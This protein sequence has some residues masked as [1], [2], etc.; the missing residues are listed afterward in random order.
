MK[1]TLIRFKNVKST[2]DVAIRLIKNQKLNRGLITSEKQTNGRGTMGKKWVSKKGNL[3][4]SLFFE[5][6]QKKVNFKNY[7]ILNAFIL[8][9]IISKFV[10]EKIK[11]KWPNDLLYKRK[12]ICGILQEVISFQR[13]NFLIIGVGLNTNFAPNNRSFSS[14]SLKDIANKRIDNKKI[15]NDIKKKNKKLLNEITKLSFLKLLKKY[16]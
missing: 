14:T 2:N 5:I 15:I 7:S 13:K 9:K 8:R 16:K 11:I 4:I 10:N 6:N 3:F 12:K 1:I